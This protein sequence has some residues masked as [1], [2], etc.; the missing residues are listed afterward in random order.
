MTD[1]EKSKVIADRLRIHWCKAGQAILGYDGMKNGMCYLCEKPL[2]E[3]RVPD[4]PDFFTP[5]GQKV[6]AG[7]LAHSNNFS[8][9]QKFLRRES[10]P[11]GGAYMTLSNNWLII[12]AETKLA[13][14]FYEFIE[15]EGK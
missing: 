4:N 13:E 1:Q 14:L 15:S 11:L 5:E 10:E 8:L 6:L 9:T 12:I 7:A 2:L 3:G